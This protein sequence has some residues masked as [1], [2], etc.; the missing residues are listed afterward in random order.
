MARRLVYLVLIALVAL[1]QDFF[2]ADDP[3]IV[4]GFLPIG[5][6]YHGAFCVAS[7][8]LWLL[9]IRY[10]WPHDLVAFAR[11]EDKPPSER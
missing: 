3:T 2:F 1:H 11:A 5:L 7:S 9:A 4:L 8:A 10:A 6:A